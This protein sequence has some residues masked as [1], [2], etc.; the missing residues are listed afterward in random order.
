MLL[1]SLLLLPLLQLL[2][3][4]LIALLLLLLALLFAL[5]EVLGFLVVSLVCYPLLVMLLDKPFFVRFSFHSS[6][7]LRRLLLLHRRPER[8]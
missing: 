2:T 6:R 5:V 3:V 4:H 7:S 1:F 8:G